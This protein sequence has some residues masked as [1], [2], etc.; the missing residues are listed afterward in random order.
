[1]VHLHLQFIM[2]ELLQQMGTESILE[3]F[4]SYNSSHN[5]RCEYAHLVQYNPFLNGKFMQ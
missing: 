3:L 5:H 1:M 4:S 2:R